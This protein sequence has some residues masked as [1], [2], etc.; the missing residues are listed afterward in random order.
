VGEV[1]IAPITQ[2]ADHAFNIL[3]MERVRRFIR[4]ERTL[5]NDEGAGDGQL[6]LS[7]RQVVATTPEHQK[8]FIG[9]A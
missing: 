7:I 6:P 1:K 2:D 4:D 8:T 3:K 5:L 9:R